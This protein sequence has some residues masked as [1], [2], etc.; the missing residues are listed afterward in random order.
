M[1][2]KLKFG[3]Q[4]ADL[5]EALIH[6]TRLREREPLEIGLVTAL[7][8]MIGP[9]RIALYKIYYRQGVQEVIPDVVL[10]DGKMALHF[11]EYDSDVTFRLDS[12]TDFVGCQDSGK[13]VASEFPCDGNTCYNYVYPVFD[14]RDAMAGFFEIV[15]EQLDAG[16]HKLI[17]GFLEIYHNYLAIIDDCQRDTLTGLLNRKTFD[18]NIA[19]IIETQQQQDQPHQKHQPRRRKGVANASHWLAVMDIDHFKSVNDR[20]GHLYGDEVL[21]LL[22]R[23]MEQTFRLQ[24]KLF[25]FGGEEFVVVLAPTSFE[26]AKNIFERFRRN[27]EEY[28]FPQVGRVTISIGFVRV[29]HHEIPSTFIGHAD[30]ALYYAKHNGRNLVCSYEKLIA[31]GVLE[32]EHFKSEMELF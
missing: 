18:N 13:M 26:D 30:E 23:I 21:L 3:A 8:R 4:E 14:N 22:A 2:H 9:R 16:S 17:D 6:F 31:E 19:K 32:S 27:I 1:F 20:F 7:N 25:R 15:C 12:R 10:D 24:D 5:L 28:D 29:A 11:D